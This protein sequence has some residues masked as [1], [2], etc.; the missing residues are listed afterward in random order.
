MWVA[1]SDFWLEH[2]SPGF[3]EYFDWDGV[4]QEAKREERKDRANLFHPSSFLNLEFSV[5]VK[6]K[7]LSYQ[8]VWNSLE[9]ISE[10]KPKS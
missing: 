6:M 7:D 8:P 9:L 4:I 1:Q 5:H 3:S 2:W 10:I